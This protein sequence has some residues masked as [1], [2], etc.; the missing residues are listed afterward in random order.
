MC[1]H[2]VGNVPDERR[3]ICPVRTRRNLDVAIGLDAAV[4]KPADVGDGAVGDKNRLVVEID[5]PGEPQSDLLNLAD[6]DVVPA[7]STMSPTSMASE[8]IS[9]RPITMSWTRLCEPKLMASPTMEALA[10]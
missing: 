5:Q 3:T 6:D 2:A 4:R 10:R 9:V 7:I 8:K 1:R